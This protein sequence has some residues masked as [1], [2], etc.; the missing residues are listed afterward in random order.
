MG[1][2]ILVVGDGEPFPEQAERSSTHSN[3]VRR[4]TFWRISAYANLPPFLYP[5]SFH[6]PPVSR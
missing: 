2:Q 5:P 4:L 1:L 3:G 6:L